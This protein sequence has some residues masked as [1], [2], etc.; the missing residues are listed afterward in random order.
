VNPDVE[1]IES[2]NQSFTARGESLIG[3]PR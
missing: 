3:R 2:H 1:G